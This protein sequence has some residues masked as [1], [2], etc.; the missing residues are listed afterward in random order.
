MT[1]PQ[2]PKW[3]PLEPI[4]AACFCLQPQIIVKAKLRGTSG[5][6]GPTP[7]AGKPEGRG[8]SR[9]VPTVLRA[10]P[11]QGWFGSAWGPG[12]IASSWTD[13]APAPR[14]VLVSTCLLFLGLARAVWP[15]KS[16]VP[17]F[18]ASPPESHSH[19]LRIGR[20]VPKKANDDTAGAE[21]GAGPR[22]PGSRA[23]AP[24]SRDRDARPRPSRPS[25][26]S[27]G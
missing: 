14:S 8:S 9:V 7:R 10:V 18:T 25:A 3:L 15:R 12:F 1:P 6:K 11:G 16:V 26:G 22:L 19:L 27:G 5:S 24:P 4:R 2:A 20:H 23:Q 17:T 21:R 13:I